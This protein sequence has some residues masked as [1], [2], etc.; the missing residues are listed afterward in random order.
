M[1]NRFD[2]IIDIVDGKVFIPDSES[3]NSFRRTDRPLPFLT[4]VR[5]RPTEFV[6][7]LREILD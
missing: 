7:P 3:T 6:P 1:K 2:Q 5:V 4:L